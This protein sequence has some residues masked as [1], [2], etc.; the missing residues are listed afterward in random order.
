MLII[1]TI[2]IIIIIIIV[3]I[4]IIMAP[5]GHWDPFPRN[6]RPIAGSSPTELP[7]SVGGDAVAVG[8][9]PT[10]EWSGY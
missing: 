5:G 4:I 2:I 7:S 9:D 6:V 8:A 1:I 10:P 3:T